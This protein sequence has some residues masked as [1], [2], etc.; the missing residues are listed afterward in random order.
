[1]HDINWGKRRPRQH[2]ASLPSRCEISQPCNCLCPPP[3]QNAVNDQSFLQVMRASHVIKGASSNLM[4]Q[5]LRE[6]A[7]ELEQAAAQANEISRD[8]D[9]AL[10]LWLT[11]VKA[12]YDVLKTAVD[13]YHGFL[14][15]VGI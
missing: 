12:K 14:D 10:E 2:F 15:E 3:L 1:M 9:S 4:C 8:D 13:D 5:K 7:T 11:I 6:G